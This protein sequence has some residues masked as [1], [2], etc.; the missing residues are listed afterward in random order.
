[1][2]AASHLKE[3]RLQRKH[4][5]ALFPF[6][7]LCFLIKNIYPAQVWFFCSWYEAIRC[8]FIHHTSVKHCIT[9][10]QLLSAVIYAF[11]SHCIVY[12]FN[13]LGKKNI[14]KEATWLWVH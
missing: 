14:T 7:T 3:I 12:F 1:M 5:L 8:V 13:H 2:E 4:H 9:Q 11:L 10:L 6:P